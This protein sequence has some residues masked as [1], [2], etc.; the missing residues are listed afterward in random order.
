M[1]KRMVFILDPP[2]TT[3]S[4]DPILTTL[5]YTAFCRSRNTVN[6]WLLRCKSRPGRRVH[7][8]F[9]GRFSMFSS[10]AI[11]SRIC[12]TV[13]PAQA[14][15]HTLGR[16]FTYKVQMHPRQAAAFIFG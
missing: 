4:F 11:R 5:D 12:D 10:F 7:L 14:G 1:P 15:I 13:I 2:S 3:V 16:Y 6:P 9:V 8:L